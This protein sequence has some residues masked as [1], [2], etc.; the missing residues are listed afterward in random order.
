LLIVGLLILNVPEWAFVGVS[1]LFSSRRAML[2]C[3][4]AM[5]LVSAFVG[6]TGVAIGIYRIYKASRR[7]EPRE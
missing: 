4:G 1:H 7:N 3:Q 6:A 2:L 5:K